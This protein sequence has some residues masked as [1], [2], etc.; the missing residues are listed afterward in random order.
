[1]RHPE[2]YLG[3][4]E[5][6]RLIAE[7]CMPGIREE[8]LSYVEIYERLADEAKQLQE[9]SLLSADQQRPDRRAAPQS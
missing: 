4:A 1:M 2:Y 7:H 6:T 9:Q 3:R 5:E 8:L